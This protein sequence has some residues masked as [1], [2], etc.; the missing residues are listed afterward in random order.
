M[1]RIQKWNIKIQREE[2]TIAKPRVKDGLGSWAHVGLVY[3]FKIGPILGKE[4]L[5]YLLQETNKK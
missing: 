1:V 2:V 5:I 3:M 4:T